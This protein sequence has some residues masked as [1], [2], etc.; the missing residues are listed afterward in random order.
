MLMMMHN[1]RVESGRRRSV[2]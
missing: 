2:N 1:I